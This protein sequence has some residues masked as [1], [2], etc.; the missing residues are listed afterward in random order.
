MFLLIF[1]V[2]QHNPPLAFAH[3]QATPFP[4]V[5]FGSQFGSGASSVG[6]G[7]LGGG[8]GVQVWGGVGLDVWVGGFG[9]SGG[10]RGWVQVVEGVG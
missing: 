3:L 10:E 9:C 1:Y 2:T 4:K 6:E 5:T 7:G 8:W